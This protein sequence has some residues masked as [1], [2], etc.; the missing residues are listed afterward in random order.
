VVYRRQS[1][2]RQQIGRKI[3]FPT[4]NIKLDGY[5]VPKLGV[6]SVKVCVNKLNKYGIANVGYRPT[7]KGKT[8]LLEVNIFGLKANLYNKSIKV[9]FLKFIRREK[10]FKNFNQLKIQIQKDIIEVKK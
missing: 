1:Y 7:L 6:Y 4:C 2:K 8:L 10:K 3:G 9:S 5:V